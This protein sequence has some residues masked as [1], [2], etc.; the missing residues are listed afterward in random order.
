MVTQ[1]YWFL[2]VRIFMKG[3]S[4]PEKMLYFK[5]SLVYIVLKISWRLHNF[6]NK[7]SNQ[8]LIINKLLLV[9]FC[10]TYFL[11]RLLSSVWRMNCF[12]CFR[13]F[14]PDFLLIRQ[15]V[16]DA[17]EDW[18]NILLGFQYGGIPSINSLHSLYNFQDR[19][20]V[21][22]FLNNDCVCHRY[23]C[24]VT[25]AFFYSCKISFSVKLISPI[26][27]NVITF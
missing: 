15:S 7:W 21:V 27:S 24:H 5:K 9:K 25:S 14:K 26:V 16:K 10:V 13:S 4:L 23:Q 1:N 12:V 18:K 8:W 19:P 22:S 2:Y 6:T 20:W 3:G 17:C 11:Y